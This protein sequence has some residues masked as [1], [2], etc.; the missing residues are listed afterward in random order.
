MSTK[1]LLINSIA[2]DVD[3]SNPDQLYHFPLGLLSLSS[4]LKKNNI[5]VRILDFFNIYYSKVFKGQ[6]HNCTPQEYIEKN[7]SQHVGD[8]KP[9]VIGVGCIFSGAFDCGKIIA[10]KSKEFFPDVPVVMGGLHATIFSVEI[11]K[12]YSQIDYIILSEGEDS[13]PKLIKYLTKNG[14]TLDSIDGITYRKDG[15][16]IKKNKTTF[17]TNLDELPFVEFDILD[18]K[19]YV[20]DTSNWYSPKKIKIGTPFPILSSRSCPCRCSFCGMWLVQGPTTR[21]RTPR[22]VVDE[23]QNLYEKYNARYFSFLDDN[24]TLDRKRILAICEDIIKR[25]LVI[26]FDT[27]N[28]VAI[29]FLD[30]EVIDA[31][32]RAG[33]VKINLA[34][35]SGSE[36]I[37][38]EAIGKRLKTE[39]IYEVFQNCAKYKHLYIGAFFVVGLPQ[40]TSE[41]LQETYEMITKLP[42]DR[43][44]VCF[45]APYP[46]T[47]LYEYCVEHGL[48][49]YN[50]KEGYDYKKE[51]LYALHP[52]F[53][54]HNLTEDELMAFLT[55]C[56]D[57][58]K[59]KR[60]KVSVPENYPLRFKDAQVNDG[61]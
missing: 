57:F 40:E 28:G 20:I 61:F 59:Q 39:K 22:N 29:N 33:L 48:L 14:V 34:P 45:A 36:Y 15:Q 8:F 21:F 18:L 55:K 30:Q 7:F 9:D 35:E 26:Q 6:L 42:V 37:R 11:L 41:T 5:E 19:N 12:K 50:H 47:K 1:V 46:G 53:K 31:M 49:K 2:T 43:I 10:K 27:P 51:Y 52:H 54:P 3:S 16:V 17:I 23:I 60:L 4:V 24:L 38:N 32:V 25:G 44:S 58:M 13:F 56:R